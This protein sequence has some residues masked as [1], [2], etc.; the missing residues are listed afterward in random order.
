MGCDV[1]VVIATWNRSDSLIRTLNSLCEQ[2]LPG[3]MFEVIVVDNNSTDG[4]ASVVSLV[5]APYNL[6][7]IFE[8]RPGRT[9]ALNTGLDAARGSIITVTDDD[10]VPDPKWLERITT[11]F[12]M[13]E[14]GLLGGPGLS[15]YPSE[16]TGDE[17]R[18]FLG[19]RFFGDFSPYDK[20]TELKDDNLPL[21]LNLSFRRVIADNIHFDISLGVFGK[22]HIGRDETDFIRRAQSLGYQV[23][24]DPGVVVHHYLEEDRVTWPRIRHKAYN[25]GIGSF[26]E[27]YS[28]RAG[29]LL[30]R[31]VLSLQF[32]GEVVYAILRIL[33]F[34]LN[35][36]KR[37]VANFR[38]AAALGKLAGLRNYGRRIL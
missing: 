30:G 24:F 2:T 28:H 31:V 4:I 16:I 37:T 25:T 22:T 33:T 5:N 6:R 18:L 21:G 7:Y 14:V 15:V 12:E 20:L 34:S 29:S 23:F 36:N 9:Y 32:E 35:R 38:L 11:R 1:S 13:P 3:E 26:K 8:G 10:C 19:R 17:Y 27:H